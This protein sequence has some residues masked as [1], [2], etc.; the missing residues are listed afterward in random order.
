MTEVAFA[1]CLALPHLA[2]DDRLAV[3]ALAV[4][5]LSVAAVVWDDPAVDWSGH[6]CVVIR[7]T[8]DYHLKPERYAAWL[9]SLASARV[10]LWNPPQAVRTNMDKRYLG[11][12]ARRGVEVVPSEYVAA[13]SDRTLR[14]ILET[15]GWSQAVVKPVVSAGAHGTWRT[16]LASADADQDR[17]HAQGLAADVMVQPYLDRVASSGEWSLV[18]FA[19]RYSHAVL[20]RPVA[21][22]FRVQEE[23]GGGFVA[24]EPPPA[25]VAQARAALSCI[26]SPLLYARVDGVEVDGRLVVMELE[27]NEPSL[28]LGS[29]PQAP[30]RFA[31]AIVASLRA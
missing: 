2:D 17:F 22:D 16:S 8:W 14:G 27:I 15:R 19:G 11:E 9:D 18:F 31:E 3:D 5:G 21:G 12:L 30:A 4:A 29:S 23:F 25:L 24:A 28:Y 7:S 13:G 20:K 6:S 1:T 26:D 10:R